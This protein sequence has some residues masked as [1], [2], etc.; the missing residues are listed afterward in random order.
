MAFEPPPTQAMATSGRRPEIGK[1]LLARLAPDDRLKLAHQIRIG[2]R[3][4]RGAQAVVGAVRIGD[5]VAQ[6]FIDGGAQSLVAARHGHDGCAEQFH[7]PDV[8]RLAL[9]VDRA[10]VDGAGHAEPRARCG[11]CDAML[12][13]AGFRN[14][15]LGAELLRK[16]HLPDRI[17]DLVRAGVRHV[18]ALQ[19][20]LRAPALG[21]LARVRQRRRAARPSS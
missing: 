7:A 3:A 4:D 5:P 8:R 17:V 1:H 11:G 18:F 2:M 13:R 10:H 15:A 12:A 16:Q 19:P 21:E 6:R 20:H 9:H 14:H